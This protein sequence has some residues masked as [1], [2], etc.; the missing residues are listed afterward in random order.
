MSLPQT[1]SLFPYKL[2]HLIETLTH[3]KTAKDFPV[4]VGASISWLSHGRAFI[5]R[6]KNLFIKKAVPAYFN[7]TLFRSFVR[8]LHLWGFK[9]LVA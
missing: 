3:D 2:Y 8:Q 6:D 4:T 9:R 5:I 7:Q 1:Q